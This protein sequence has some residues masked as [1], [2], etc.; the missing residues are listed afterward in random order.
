MN[1]CTCNVKLTAGIDEITA[2]LSVGDIL[3]IHSQFP[4]YAGPY[5]ITPQAHQAQTLPT[6]QKSLNENITV[7]EIPVYEV[8]NEYGITVNIGG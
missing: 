4:D 2:R 7:L 8:S 1:N 6:A 3:I 5:T